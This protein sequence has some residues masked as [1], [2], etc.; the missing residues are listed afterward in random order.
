MKIASGYVKP[1]IYN[2]IME[3]KIRC[4]GKPMT[5]IV[6]AGGRGSRMRT[7]KAALAVKGRTLLEHVLVQ[8]EPY[9]EETLISVTPGQK[10]AAARAGTAPIRA[11]KRDPSMAG[12][13]AELLPRGGGRRFEVVEDEAPGL[14]PLGGMLT[15]LRASSSDACAVIACDIPDIPLPLLRSLAR[16]AQGAEIAV[17]VDTAGRYEPLFAVYKRA[18]IP[19]IEALLRSGERSI[20]P[21][22]ERCRTA[23]VRLEAGRRLTNLNTRADYRDYL[24][25]LRSD[26]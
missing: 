3:R 21:L 5:A 26:E 15:G 19:E 6:L 12:P 2:K 11:G 23:V 10:A 13:G 1:A 8:I 7:D 17:P 25:S 24:K 14:G 18:V 22:F 16:A 20:L 9:F 4:G